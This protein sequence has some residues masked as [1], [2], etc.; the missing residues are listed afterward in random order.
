M[1]KNS[2]NINFRMKVFKNLNEIKEFI[3]KVD[4]NKVLNRRQRARLINFLEK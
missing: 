3:D 2:K 4:N 1:L